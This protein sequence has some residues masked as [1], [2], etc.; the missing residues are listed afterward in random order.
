MTTH[1]NIDKIPK[2]T[3]YCYE[4]ITVDMS[5]GRMKIKVCPYWSEQGC[6]FLDLNTKDSILLWDQVKEC[7][8]NLPDEECYGSVK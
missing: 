4:I 5:T 6:S 1:G 2:N 3:D 8:V 7:D